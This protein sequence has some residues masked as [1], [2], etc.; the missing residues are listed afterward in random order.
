MNIMFLM[1]CLVMLV[2]GVTAH[3]EGFRFKE[4][5]F[6]VSFASVVVAYVF[7]KTLDNLFILIN[8]G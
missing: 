1:H 6:M 4:K 5:P 7:A 3:I 2:F 8:Q